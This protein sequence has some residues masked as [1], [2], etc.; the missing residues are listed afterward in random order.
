VTPVSN[1]SRVS[2]YKDTL[3]IQIDSDNF[4]L[5]N[6]NR[7]ITKDY[8][9]KL[10]GYQWQGYLTMR[11]PG[12]TIY[13][14]PAVAE[15][16]ETNDNQTEWTFTLREGVRFHDGTLC[17]AR[18]VKYSFAANFLAFYGTGLIGNFTTGGSFYEEYYFNVTY[19]ESD[20]NGDGL[21]FSMNGGWWP[22]QAFMLD[23]AG[24]WNLFML[25]PEGSNGLYT[26]DVETI[27]QK[28]A[29]FEENPISTGPYKFSERLEQEHIIF[30]RFDD[31]F[32]WGQTVIDNAGNSYAFPSQNE[33][34]KYVKFRTISEFDTAFNELENGGVDLI[35]MQVSNSENIS[36]MNSIVDQAEFDAF[37]IDTLSGTRLN[38]NVEGDW[39]TAFGGPGNYPVSEEWFRKVVSHA[40]NRTKIVENAYWGK[41]GELDTIYPDWVLEKFP[42][43]DTSDYYDLGYDPLKAINILIYNGYT[44]LGF[45]DEIYNRFGYGPFLNETMATTTGHHFRVVATNRSQ[46]T[47]NQALAVQEDL[48]AVGI[49]V[50][51]EFLEWSN[52]L[53]ALREGDEGDQYNQSYV[54]LGIP[55]P[56]WYGP[57]WDF[58]L[59][60]FGY[61]YET[62]QQFAVYMGSYAFFMW[63]GSTPSVYN[64]DYEK[65]VAKLLGGN[66]FQSEF[67]G[68]ST[69]EY[70]YPEWSANDTQYVEAAEECGR[71][72]S[73]ML[74][75]IPLTW[76]R[77]IYTYNMNLLNFCVDRSGF[78]HCAYT[79]WSSNAITTTT[80][81]PTTETTIEP[82]TA[83]ETITT[84][85]TTTTEQTVQTSPGFEISVCMIA[86]MVLLFLFKKKERNFD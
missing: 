9:S 35:T 53:S 66:G 55:D 67:P 34:F 62:P 60:E 81:T 3:V 48:E 52:Y 18:D 17:T 8:A 47:I 30:E 39:P 41:A 85:T 50:D 20:P 49:Y 28:M 78:F 56:E 79:Y 43:I 19:P 54:A 76:N 26:D 32:G 2:I 13:S 45:T 71:L 29:E 15:S 16:W 74:S 51:V 70:P 14:Y 59:G 27:D 25:V 63:Y 42:G 57:S 10:V 82:T 37:I 46:Q 7:F 65:N 72:M 22:D 1:L 73:N 6:R 44:P 77:D 12:H 24:H 36:I 58:Y 38:P 21:V 75:T 83:T 61:D 33:A 86:T 40:I 11:T 69:D 80:T 84:T 23:A 64:A 68:G 4:K 31:W 5:D